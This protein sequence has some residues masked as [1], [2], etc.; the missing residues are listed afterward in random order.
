MMS[1]CRVKQQEIILKTGKFSVPA[2][3]RPSTLKVDCHIERD[4]VIRTEFITLARL[5]PTDYLDIY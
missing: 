5:L 4:R 1:R 3:M 2:E